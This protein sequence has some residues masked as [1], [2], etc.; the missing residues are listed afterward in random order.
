M[1]L[2][3]WKVYA[4]YIVLTSVILI[5]FGISVVSRRD[6]VPGRLQI[7]IEMM[8]QYLRDTFM[9][10]LGH[11]GERH[12]PLIFGLFWYILFC[13][14]LG[15]IPG[16]KAAT[17]N[18]STTIGLGIIVF[19]Y[20]QYVGIKSKG[21]GNYLKHFLGPLLVLAPLFFVIEILGEFVKPFSLGMR[22]FGNIYAED[23]MNDLAAGAGQKY[24][25]PFQII[26]YFLQIFTGVI[27]AFI[28]SLLSCA[29]IGLMAEHH[30]DNGDSYEHGPH[31][32]TMD[33]KMASSIGS[34]GGR[35]VEEA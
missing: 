14:M 9:G 33:E 18:P 3:D 17:A 28:F 27:Q 6:K 22:L 20:S 13:D 26:V 15:L 34:I 32:E 31:S 12:L 19:V 7:T 25:I 30:D 10:A 21:L 4:L 16:F 1:E 11:G 29:Y 23:I 24:Y 5:V 35:V 8:M 2:L